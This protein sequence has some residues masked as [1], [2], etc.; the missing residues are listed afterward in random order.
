[1][2]SE[3]G[4]VVFVV[5]GKDTRFG[6]VDLESEIIEGTA[7]GFVPLVPGLFEAIER[8][9]KVFDGLP[10]IVIARGCLHVDVFIVTELSVEI[11]PVE[12]KSVDLPVIS[13]YSWLTVVSD[14]DNLG[15]F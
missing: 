5:G 14:V 8:F 6:I 7:E 12:V 4:G 3:D 2:D 13:C 9:A 1:M 10:L 15:L 11:C